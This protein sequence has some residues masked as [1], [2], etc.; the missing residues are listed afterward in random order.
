[1]KGLYGVA[2]VW[3]EMVKCK[4]CGK[5]IVSGENVMVQFDGMMFYN[6]MEPVPKRFGS[7][8]KYWHLNCKTERR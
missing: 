7:L 1:M 3:L 4:K 8:T 2:G 6:G 5:E